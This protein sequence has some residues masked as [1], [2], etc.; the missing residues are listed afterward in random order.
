MHDLTLGAPVDVG[1]NPEATHSGSCND[2]VFGCSRCWNTANDNLGTIDK[3]DWC[4]RE[5]HTKV[6]KAW[7]EPI[8]YALCLAC[9]NKN[10][11]PDYTHGE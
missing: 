5:T 1:V 8:L 10:R 9:R 11:A 4:E 7:D 6:S 3:C 2:G